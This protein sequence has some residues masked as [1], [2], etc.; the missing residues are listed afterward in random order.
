[1]SFVNK[2]ITIPKFLQELHGKQASVFDILLVYTV[3]ILTTAG[4]LYMA[5]DLPLKI[6]KAIILAV[7]V[8]DL[9]GGIVS[10]FTEGTNIY[11]NE[12]PKRRKIFT[13]LHVIQP[14]LLVWIFPL[15]FFS[16]IVISS[17]TLL[18]LSIVNSLKNYN[19]QKVLAAFFV[20]FGILLSFIIG[21]YQ[22]IVHI[23]LILFLIKLTLAFAVR[24]E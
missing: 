13:L 3:A 2:K 14:T 10:N 7:L 12:S 24:W 16:I 23:M 11:Y 6:Y 18:T 22:P 1:M 17:Y 9:S 4:I 15:D 5:W 19:K 8:A 21:V 20:V